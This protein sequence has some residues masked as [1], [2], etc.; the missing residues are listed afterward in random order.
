MEAAA[1]DSRMALELA[2]RIQKEELELDTDD[3]FHP[4][5]GY[6]VVQVKG[7]EVHFLR[8]DTLHREDGPAVVTY[9]NGWPMGT[10]YKNGVGMPDLITEDDFNEME[11]VERG[12]VANLA[13]D[14]GNP[15]HQA[16]LDAISN[17]LM[18]AHI[19]RRMKNWNPL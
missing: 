2:H 18:T 3:S 5:G 13:L 12:V 8:G 9:K 7:N 1:S 6:S 15:E 19:V 14:S 17:A 11:T 4:T 10:Y 16:Q